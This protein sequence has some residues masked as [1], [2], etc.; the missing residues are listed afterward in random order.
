MNSQVIHETHWS[1]SRIYSS[2]KIALK[3]FAVLAAAFI[4]GWLYVA[5]YIAISV[6]ALL[7]PRR[8][9]ESLSLSW[10]LTFLNP[11]IFNVSDGA[12]LFRWVTLLCAFF[13]VIIRHLFSSSGVPRTLVWGGIFVAVAAVLSAVKS[14]AV[15]VSLF[16]LITFLMGT[17]TV[18][19]AY[20]QT[21]Y[22]GDYWERWFFILFAIII[23]CGFVFIFSSPGYAVNPSLFQGI[24]LA[25]P[26]WNI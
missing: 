11:D 3:V 4:G 2:R 17:L 8:A 18:L 16:K 6:W 9:L 25:R 12:L 20:Q 14:Y 13:S 10:L 1:D 23:L 15:D 21:K 24:L 22:L 5:A 26:I 19:L 7:G